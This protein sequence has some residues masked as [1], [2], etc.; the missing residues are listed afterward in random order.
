MPLHNVLRQYETKIYTLC[1][2]NNDMYK[3]LTKIIH[4]KKY[5]EDHE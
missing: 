5:E 2:K 4:I 3:Y 1:V